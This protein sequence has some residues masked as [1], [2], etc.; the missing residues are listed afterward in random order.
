MEIKTPKQIKYMREGGQILAS[1]LNTLKTYL[2][3]GIT[4]EE[5]AKLARSELARLGAEAAFLNYQGFPSVICISVNDEVVHGIPG[6]RRLSNG[7]IVGLDFGVKHKGLITDSAISCIVGNSAGKE[8]ETL[9]NTTQEALYAGI[10]EV[11][12]GANIGT[13]SAAIERTLR[14]RNFGVIETLVGHGVGKELHEPP[15]IP[16]FGKIGSGKALRA[17]MTIAIEPMATLGGKD[18]YLGE[19]GWTVKTKDKSLSAHFEHTVLVTDSGC[20]ILTQA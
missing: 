3:E 15:E 4:T 11:K 20:E 1:V 14:K 6:K 18:V 9:L 16:N 8:V 17:G 5:L 12:H 2:R 10:R 19:D 13:I 7:D